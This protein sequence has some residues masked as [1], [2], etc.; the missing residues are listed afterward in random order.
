MDDTLVKMPI[1][2]SFDEDVVFIDD[3]MHKSRFKI[4]RCKF[5]VLPDIDMAGLRCEGDCSGCAG[6]L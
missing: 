1:A 3:G 6:C 2:L 5:L 4:S